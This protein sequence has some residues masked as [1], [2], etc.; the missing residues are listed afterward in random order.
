MPELTELNAG[1][2]ITLNNANLYNS[3]S[4][5]TAKDVLTGDYYLYD[6]KVVNNRIRI[7]NLKT[8]VGLKPIAQHTLGWVEIDKVKKVKA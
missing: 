2:K 4:I 6:V 5:K 7:T 1:D 8:N 3:S